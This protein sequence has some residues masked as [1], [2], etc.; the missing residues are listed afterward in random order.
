M[1]KVAMCVKDKEEGQCFQP[2]LPMDL[3]GRSE[4]FCY[5]IL[6]LTKL[7]AAGSGRG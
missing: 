7:Q 3:L 6:P 5:Q 2:V 1:E 4:G